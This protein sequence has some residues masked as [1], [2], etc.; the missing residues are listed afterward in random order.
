MDRAE[1]G[2]DFVL[3]VRWRLQPVD[4]VAPSPLFGG[5]RSGRPVTRRRRLARLN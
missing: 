3:V 2:L 1:K 5:N 4:A